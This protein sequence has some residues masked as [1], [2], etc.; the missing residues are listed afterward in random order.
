MSSAAQAVRGFYPSLLAGDSTGLIFLFGGPPK[1]DTPFEG[2]V[3]GSASL[4]RFVT[5]QKNWLGEREAEVENVALTETDSCVVAEIVLNLKHGE[6]AIQLPVALVADIAGCM[7]TWLRIYHS[8]W[9]LTGSHRVRGPFMKR[10]ARLAKPETVKSYMYGIRKPDKEKVLSLF[11]EDGYVREPSGPDYIHT[12]PDEL[13]RFY[14]VALATGGI[15]LAHCSAT[16][17]GTCCAIEYNCDSWGSSPIPPQ[18]GCAVYEMNEDEQ[19]VGVRIY[20]DIT[21]PSEKAP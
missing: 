14:S 12:G 1:I 9:P 8:T 6:K 17:D 3:E 11:T 10:A 15:P 5:D 7:V 20:D 2:N 18:A 19:I 16:F 21:P 4:Q 13:D